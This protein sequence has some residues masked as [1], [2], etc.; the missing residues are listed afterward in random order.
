M[1]FLASLQRPKKKKKLH[2]NNLLQ[3]SNDEMQKSRF[4]DC[5]FLCCILLNFFIIITQRFYRLKVIVYRS[6]LT[7]SMC[8]TYGKMMSCE[9]FHNNCMFCS[10]AISILFC[11]VC[12]GDEIKEA[13]ANV[14]CCFTLL[15]SEMPKQLHPN[16]NSK[17][18]SVM[19][20]SCH[21]SHAVALLPGSNV[22]VLYCIWWIV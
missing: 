19:P 2:C 6:F 16:Q 12:I 3:I 4:P 18:Q 20:D 14:I 17:I 15:P 13:A 1:V 21:V 11:M 10:T 5:C 7:F 9:L 22:M 8:Q